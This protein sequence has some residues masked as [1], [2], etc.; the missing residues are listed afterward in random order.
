MVARQYS[1]ASQYFNQATHGGGGLSARAQQQ[2]GAIQLRLE[3]ESFIQTQ[4]LLSARELLVRTS[5][6][7]PVTMSGIQLRL[8]IDG[9]A[10]T[11]RLS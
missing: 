5:K 1:Q 9:Q 6:K 3:P 8:T 10:Q 7:S 4:L 2:L 11:L